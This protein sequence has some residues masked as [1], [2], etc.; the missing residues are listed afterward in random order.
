[1]PQNGTK[2]EKHSLISVSVTS[3][4]QML[5]LINEY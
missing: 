5:F 1:M 3:N 4:K 2:Q